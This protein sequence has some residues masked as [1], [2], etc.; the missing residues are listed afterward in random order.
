MD[1]LEYHTTEKIRH[2]LSEPYSHKRPHAQ[3]KTVNGF[4]VTKIMQKTITA[5]I[6]T[7]LLRLF[8][9]KN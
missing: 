9:T 8:L 2:S 7:I 1:E 6:L 3:I 4:D 5:F